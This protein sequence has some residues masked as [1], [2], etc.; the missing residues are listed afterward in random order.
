MAR[1]DRCARGAGTGMSRGDYA[2]GAG[3]TSARRRPTAS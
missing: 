2:T 3:A 1:H